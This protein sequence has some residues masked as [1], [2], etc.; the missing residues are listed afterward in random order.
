MKRGMQ[1]DFLFLGTSG[2]HYSP[3]LQKEYVDQFDLDARRSSSA[4]INGRYLIDCG[5]HCLDSLRIAGV[6]TAQIT[7]VFLTHLH[8]DHFRKAAFVKNV[9]CYHRENTRLFN[10]FGTPFA[11]ISRRNRPIGKSRRIKGGLRRIASNN[12]K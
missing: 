11:Q 5:D 12:I 3:Q 4:L 1:L 8:H 6:N 7:D 9:G 10:T 2:G